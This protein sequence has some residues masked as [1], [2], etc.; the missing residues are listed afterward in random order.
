[1]SRFLVGLTVILS[2]WVLT[3]T[4]HAS[5]WSWSDMISW[6]FG[7]DGGHHYDKNGH[8]IPELDPGVTGSAMVLLLG[9]VAYIASRRRE[10]TL[11]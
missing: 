8:G 6:F 10:D 3:P 7:G 5:A 2:V 11:G 4:P 9:G 1:M